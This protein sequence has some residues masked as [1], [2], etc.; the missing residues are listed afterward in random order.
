[1]AS[2]KALNDERQKEWGSVVV[3]QFKPK[4]EGSV[5]YQFIHQIVVDYSK[6]LEDDPEEFVKKDRL[7]A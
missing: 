2:F 1:M 7:L 4:G 5:V 6:I 3:K